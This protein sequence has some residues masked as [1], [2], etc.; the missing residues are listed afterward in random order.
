M[1]I[2][3]IKKYTYFDIWIIMTLNVTVMLLLQLFFGNVNEYNNVRTVVLLNSYVG[4]VTLCK[5]FMGPEI[6][7]DLAYN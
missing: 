4:H 6:S 5:L 1:E 2:I 3:I 7:S